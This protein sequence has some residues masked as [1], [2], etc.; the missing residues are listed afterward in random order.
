MHGFWNMC[1]QQV[2]DFPNLLIYLY[3]NEHIEIVPGAWILLHM[4]P[5]CAKNKSLISD[6][7]KIHVIRTMNGGQL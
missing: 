4:H 2:H 6:T 5:V 1:T 3:R 7:D